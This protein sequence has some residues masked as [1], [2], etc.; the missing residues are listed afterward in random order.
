MHGMRVSP[1]DLIHADVHGAVV[2]PHDVARDIP[3]VVADQMEM[4]SVLIGASQAE[5]FSAEVYER[6]VSSFGPH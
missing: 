1:G 6:L 4:E 3:G 5:G 2:I